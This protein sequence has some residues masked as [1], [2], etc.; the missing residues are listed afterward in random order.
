MT[1]KLEF[2]AAH[3]VSA[4]HATKLSFREWLVLREVGTSTACVA[5]YARPLLPPVR[6]QPKKAPA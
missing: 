1:A 3:R 6:R 5:A 4:T 2:M